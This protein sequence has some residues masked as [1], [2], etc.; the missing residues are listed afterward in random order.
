MLSLICPMKPSKYWILLLCYLSHSML[1]L[2]PHTPV[3]SASSRNISLKRSDMVVQEK[4]PS[5]VVGTL[6][7]HDVRTSPIQSISL[8][9]IVPTLI[10]WGFQW[11]HQRLPKP[12]PRES[13]PSESV[14]NPICYVCTHIFEIISNKWVQQFHN[15]TMHFRF[16]AFG[17]HTYLLCTITCHNIVA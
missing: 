11:Q 1:M 8:D 9:Y 14:T 15:G 16:M 5:I 3:V 4:P 17:S 6:T 7:M 2:S 10:S 12:R 13:T